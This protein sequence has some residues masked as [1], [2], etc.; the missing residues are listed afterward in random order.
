MNRREMRSWMWAEAVDM[1]DQADRLQRQFFRLAVQP[2]DP[3]QQPRWEP[4]V[5]V[6]AGTEQ[7][8]I[9]V[10]LPGVPADRMELVLGPASW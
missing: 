2:A 9:E 8:L 5:D 10:A 3:R 7:V 1:L 6:Y 4:P